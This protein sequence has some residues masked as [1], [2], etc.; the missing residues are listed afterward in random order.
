MFRLQNC[1]RRSFFLSC[2]TYWLDS[3]EQATRNL[4]RSYWGPDD[5]TVSVLRIVV[6]Y[7]YIPKQQLSGGVFPKFYYHVIPCV[8]IN[9]SHSLPSHIQVGTERIDGKLCISCYLWLMVYCLLPSHY[10]VVLYMVPVLSIHVTL[11]LIT[12]ATGCA[13]PRT[14]CNFRYGMFGHAVYMSTV[15][16]RDTLNTCD[17]DFPVRQQVW[18]D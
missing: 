6:R 4:Y 18:E 5:G 15:A 11:L 1:P 10:T 2:S 17:R 3:C 8:R 13:I 16:F 9:R 7:N 12:L 14:K